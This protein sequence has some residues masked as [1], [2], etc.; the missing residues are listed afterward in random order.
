[1][2]THNLLEHDR[3][4]PLRRPTP[5]DAPAADGGADAHPLLTLQRQVGNAQIARMLAQRA[6]LPVEDEEDMV[7]A[8]HDPSLLQREGAPEP[9]EE[10]E[11]DMVQARHDPAVLQREEMPEE[12]EEDMVQARHDPSLLQ[13]EG[14]PEEEDEQAQQLMQARPEVGLAG[15]PVSADLAGRIQGQRGSGAPLD[16]GTRV[17]MEQSFGTSFEGVRVHSDA[18]SAQLNQNISAKAFTTG[19]D[20]F[21]GQGA[22]A[23]DRDLMAHELTHVVQQ[24]DMS[25]S[26]PMTVGPAGDSYEQQADATAAAVTSGAAAAQRRPEEDR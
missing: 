2:P 3:I 14:A 24:R 7:Q 21:L 15:G 1:M 23:S 19:S 10:D 12:D 9:E 20:I 26:G 17:G 5:A 13:R 4:A 16:E 8:K 11:E 25:A 18:E 6:D 22:S